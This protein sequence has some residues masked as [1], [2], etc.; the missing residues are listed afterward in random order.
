MKIV[1]LWL[2]FVQHLIFDLLNKFLSKFEQSFCS[3]LLF[4]WKF[5]FVFYLLL[6]IIFIDINS[7]F[8][9]FCIVEDAIFFVVI[10]VKLIFLVVRTPITEVIS[11]PKVK[12]VADIIALRVIFFDVVCQIVLRIQ[13]SFS[14][15][16]ELFK[17][18][19]I[20]LVAI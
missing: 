8:F 16:K 15:L 10:K 7:I 2:A 5:F 4:L 13:E 9:L 6:A 17:G 1:T 20:K 11:T 18:H 19:L 14:Q 12:H 3:S